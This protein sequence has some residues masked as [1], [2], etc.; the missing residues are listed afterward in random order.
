MN[1][2]Q[3]TRDRI[4]SLIS[5]NSVLLFMKGN[6]AGPQC[7][8]SATVV[9]LLDRL[10]SDYETFDVLADQPLRE[11]IKAFSNWPT[12]P[13]LYVGGEFL[14][15]CDII[16]D[17]YAS[18]ELHEKLGVARPATA[19]PTITVTEKALAE[20]HRLATERPGQTLH[21]TVDA[22]FQNGLYFGP[23]EAGD[24]NVALEGLSI[25]ID[26]VS[27]GRA[28]G[29]TVDVVETDQGVG[30]AIDNPNAPKAVDQITVG[31]L[32][33][34]IERGDEFVFLDVRT[35]QERDIAEI[36]GARLLDESLA[37]ELEALPRDTMLVFH[38]HHGGRSQAAAEHFSAHGFSDVHNVVGGI[39]AWSV[40]IDPSVPRY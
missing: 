31:E 25:S 34:L 37:A 8:F 23:D 4:D 5:E 9:G 36:P 17:L 19:A 6:R 30:F 40:E 18:G 14:G 16:Q 20:L 10:I 1:L 33:E 39:E 22:R 2:D 27:A 13:Q 29:L 26:P 3:P 35:Q 11:A 32:K 24:L 12:I 38:C 7:G 21:L 28:E 15:G